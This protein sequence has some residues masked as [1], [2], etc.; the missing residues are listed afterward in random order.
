M[1]GEIAMRAFKL[2]KNHRTVVSYTIIEKH[3]IDADEKLGWKATENYHNEA[4]LQDGGG[5]YYKS[6]V[7]SDANGFKMFGNTKANQKIFIVGDSFTQAIEVSNDKTYYGV[8]AKKIN[9]MEIFTYGVRGYGSLQEFMVIDKL[10][11]EIKPQLLI[12][13]LCPNDFINNDYDLEVRSYEN[14]NGMRRPYLDISGNIFYKNPKNIADPP[15]ILLRY[16]RL[17]NFMHNKI[18]VI[19]RDINKPKTIEREIEREGQG[20]RLFRQSEAITK[21]IMDMIKARTSGTPVITFC[22]TDTQPYYDA[23]KRMAGLEGFGFIEGIPEAI[24]AYEQKGY[25]AVA[26]DQGHWNE[27]GH[28]IAAEKIYEFLVSRGVISEKQAE[29]TGKKERPAAARP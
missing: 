18:E 6:V 28:R 9:N 11:D 20:H 27:L 25:V 7:T 1:V 24:K 22:F 10:I 19:Y 29:T 14:N 23:F 16:S 8:L 5:N 12:L 3:P 13:Q 17:I 15:E 2:V 26:A 4:I 21:K